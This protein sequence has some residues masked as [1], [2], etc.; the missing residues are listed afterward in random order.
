MERLK[1]VASS[2]SK[3]IASIQQAASEKFNQ[4][5][6]S[7]T[8]STMSKLSLEEEFESK[9]NKQF[10][11]QDSNYEPQSGRNFSGDMGCS[12]N[13]Q[14]D[15]HSVAGTGMVQESRLAAG[16]A[17]SVSALPTGSGSGTTTTQD[18]N[19]TAA[20]LITSQA[21]AHLTEEEKEI[22]LQVFRR[23]EQFRQETLR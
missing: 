5:A 12:G 4:Q 11:P 8:S 3:V 13:S 2:S 9:C 21:T 23:E 6:S 22:L 15:H 14:I 18:T 10:S 20:Q 1:K 19:P 7:Q 17:S 16:L